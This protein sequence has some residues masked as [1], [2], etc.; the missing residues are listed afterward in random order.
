VLLTAAHCV[1]EN[2]GALFGLF[3]GASNDTLNA[4]TFVPAQRAVAH[5][6]YNINNEALEHDL[7]VV[8]LASPAPMAPLP[9]NRQALG[10]ENIGQPARYVGYGLSDGVARTGSGI[11]RETTQAIAEIRRT[12]I[13][14]GTNPHSACNGDSGGPLLMKGADGR[15]AIVGVV[16]FGDDEHCA[17][18]SYFQRLD[19]QIAWVDEQ[20]ARY[21]PDALLPPPVVVAGDGGASPAGGSADATVGLAPE[22]EPPVVTAPVTG[23]DAGAEQPQAPP[24]TEMPP[25]IATDPAPPE[26]AE[27]PPI[28]AEPGAG[29]M[30]D[31]GA[32]DPIAGAT[33]ASRTPTGLV[34]GG[35]GGCQYAGRQ[36]QLG[37]LSA[38]LVTLLG[39]V[40]V[41]RRRRPV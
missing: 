2:A 9:M 29:G 14:I 38:L 18:S 5:P 22:A 13:R 32:V 7:A 31:G 3:Y 17:Q 23:S 41:R 20:I 40:T 35:G 4:Q 26:E 19:T 36:D 6:A 21:D 25:P 24:V 27:L 8:V 15:E 30:A 1:A 11:K 10:A 34:L 12:Y 33:V 39:A 28:A 16:S 37:G